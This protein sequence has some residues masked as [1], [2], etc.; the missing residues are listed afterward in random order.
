M[1]LRH[2]TAYA[3]AKRY[4]Y[5]RPPHALAPLPLT[6]DAP[7]RLSATAGVPVATVSQMADAAGWTSDLETGAYVPVATEAPGGKV[8]LMAQLKTLTDYVAHVEK[9][10]K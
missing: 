6:L 2:R 1:P 5:L 10:L 3:S 7:S 4:A 9:E 8:D